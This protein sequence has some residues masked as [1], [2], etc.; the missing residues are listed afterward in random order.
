MRQFRISN[1]E[2]RIASA[3]TFI[4]ALALSVLVVPLATDAQQTGKMWRIGALMP[5]GRST[6][7]EVLEGLHTLNYVEG[8][9][10]ILEQRRYTKREQLPTLAT[11]L[12]GLKP[13]VI[14]AGTGTAA[15]ALKAVTTTLPIV[16]AS[17]GDAVV[18]GLVAS[19]A[20]PG[21]NVTGSTAISA[22]LVAKRFELLIEAAPRIAR[23]GVMG[24]FP[25]GNALAILQWSEA[26][27]AG[28]KMGLHLVPIFIRK[29]EELLGAFERATQQKIDGVLVQDAGS[30]PKPEHVVGLV[31]TSRVPDIYPYPW[32]VQAGGLMSYGPNSA[33]MHRRAAIFVDKILKGAKPADLPVEQPTRYDLVINQKT[34][35]GIGLTIPSSVLMRADQVIE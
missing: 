35:K 20:R 18:Q 22:D 1:C 8:R 16:V 21:G 7:E 13:D 4:V 17:S 9:N 32:Y 24:G 25:E 3:A 23:I 34:A 30:L 5:E 28:R 10:F 12:V 26:E 11:E 15:L 6:M 14:I 27:S 19:L 29:P 31:K 2:F 33:E